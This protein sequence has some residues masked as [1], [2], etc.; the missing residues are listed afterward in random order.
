MNHQRTNT[1]DDTS[2]VPGDS[3]G[4]MWMRLNL[5]TNGLFL[6]GFTAAVV[7]AMHNRAGDGKII[8]NWFPVTLMSLSALPYFLA[9]FTMRPRRGTGAESM[10]IIVFVAVAMRVVMLFAP[11]LSGGDYT[12]YMWDGAVT[13]KGMN[14][15]RHSPKQ[16]LEGDVEDPQLRRL[17]SGGRG[18]LEGITHRRLRTIYPPVAQG[19]FAVAHWI[20]PF[21][22]YGWLIVVAAMDALAAVAILG[23][24]RCAHL[25]G[26]MVLVYLWNPL[27]VNEAWQGGHVDVATAAMLAAMIWALVSRRIILA[28]LF[29]ALAVGTKLWPAILVFF[30]VRP[31]VRCRRRGAAGVALAAGLLTLLAIPWLEALG[32]G[33]T[34]GTVAYAR[35]WTGGAWA[36]HGIEAAGK[37]IR[38]AFGL[39]VS[40]RFFGRA[41]S[42]A[43]LFA[44]AALFGLVGSANPRHVCRRMGTV[45]VLMLLLSP[46]VWPWYYLPA[47]APASL[48]AVTGGRMIAAPAVVFPTALLPVLYEFAGVMDGGFKAALVHAPVWTL[49]AGQWAW[50]IIRRIRE[51]RAGECIEAKR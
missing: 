12:R 19:L 15:Y 40:L 9:V 4:K 29:W 5:L 30:L 41:L 3:A 1:A 28:W 35:T 34:S 39:E 22:L 16:V 23:A 18:V 49:L 27:L 43:C 46:M 44:A 24:L 25:P 33:E 32:A 2:E 6:V 11:Q 38:D 36:Y 50:I 20:S 37:R 48:C 31:T 7:A 14:P 13:A 26:A 8:Y 42:A 21:R 47:L 10:A 51:R 17:A 45:I